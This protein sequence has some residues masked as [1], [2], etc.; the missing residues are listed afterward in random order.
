MSFVN[1]GAFQK[2]GAKRSNNNV[3]YVENNVFFFYLEPCK[4]IALYQMHKIMLFL[5]T[6]YDPFKSL[7]VK[8]KNYGIF[9]SGNQ[10]L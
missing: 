9:I 3:Q 10:L 1:I 7:W 8:Q 4:H 2:G 5:A 6:S